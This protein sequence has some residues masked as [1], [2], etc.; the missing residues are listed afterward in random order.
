M[1]EL[2][3]V[4]DLVDL[5]HARAAEVLDS[6]HAQLVADVAHS[7][8]KRQGFLGE[9]LVV[10]L[11]GG[12]GSGKS[13]ILNALVGE[14][15]VT[16]GVVRPTT[17]IATAAFPASCP[18]DLAPLLD[19]LAVDDRMAFDGLES[20]VFVDLP[21]FDSTQEAHRHI[22]EEVLHRVDA[23]VWVLD[24]EKYA[25][26]LLHG[27][28]LSGLV[29]HEH[30]F[31]FALNQMDRL[32]DEGERVLASLTDHLRSDGF[33]EPIVVGSI[34][35]NRDGAD[36]DVAELV[37]MIDERLDAKS[38]ALS[39]LAVD[40]RQLANEGWLACV[41]AGNEASD[42]SAAQGAA[43]AAATFV[44]LGVASYE[45]Y[46]Q[47]IRHEEERLSWMTSETG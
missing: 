23:V 37:R 46:A 31:I 1:V 2:T 42:E 11:A 20:V 17:Q 30:Q 18:S 16:T 36:P 35:V 8:R 4:L 22:V 26:P 6:D 24:P 39:K 41:D 27:E 32:G 47:T 40:L 45:L 7:V 19:A 38:T 29:D 9:V 43:I 10:A 14:E 21:D 15:I 3:E 5:A 44:S 25:D 28:F 12:T 33:V 13:S 34:A